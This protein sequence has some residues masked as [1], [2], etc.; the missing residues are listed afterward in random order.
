MKAELR[1]IFATEGRVLIARVTGGLGNQVFSYALIS[2]FRAKFGYDVYIDL[3]LIKAQGI[4]RSFELSGLFSGLK[5]VDLSGAHETKDG[6]YFVLGGVHYSRHPNP[7]NWSSVVAEDKIV[8]E[9]IRSNSL[10][11]SHLNL[12]TIEQRFGL[13]TARL[14]SKAFFDDTDWLSNTLVIHVRR[15]DYPFYL[16]VSYYNDAYKRLTKSHNRFRRILVCTDDSIWVRNSFKFEPDL[17]LDSKL[18]LSVDESFLLLIFGQTRILSEGTYSEASLIIS[19]LLG[20]DCGSTCF[21]VVKRV[22]RYR[23]M[24]PLGVGIS[25]KPYLPVITRVRRRISKAKHWIGGMVRK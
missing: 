19:V 6:K 24:A 11:F 7:L 1:E 3:S 20:R 14:S 15:G 13:L 12:D 9:N 17:Y 16:P 25:V 18:G 5:L 8:I 22:S 4:H 23:F 2:L 10:F 21:P